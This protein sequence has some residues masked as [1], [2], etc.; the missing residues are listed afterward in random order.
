[1]QKL[2]RPTMIGL[3][4]SLAC[5]AWFLKDVDF[6]RLWELARGINPL[7]A[8]SSLALLCVTFWFRSLR[9]RVLLA[10]IKDCPLGG[11][12]SANLIGFMAN[13]VLPARLGEFVRAYAAAKLVQVPASGALATIVVE[14]VLDGLALCAMLFTTLLFVEPGARAGSFD[15][16]FLRGAGVTLLGVFLFAL[17]VLWGLLIWPGRV[18]SLATGL[19]GRISPKLSAWVGEALSGFSQGLAVLKRGRSLLPLVLL[20]GAVWLPVL[21][22]NTVFLPAVGMPPLVFWGALALVGENMASA[23]PAAPGYVGTFQLAVLWALVLGGA[24]EDKATAY[25]ILFWALT[26]FA[27]T[28]GGLFEMWR[29]GMSLGSLKRQGSE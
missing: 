17:A 21:G 23:V 15:L 20:T 25:A 26:Y 19:A 18:M 6:T 24:P 7:Y 12:L 8:L 16:I 11:L 3:V 2:N 27:V 1:M 9:W 22:M 5:L 28:L 29:R 14:R 10:P 4:V 13:N